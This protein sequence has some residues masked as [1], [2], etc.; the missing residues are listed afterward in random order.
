MFWVRY[1]RCIQ[2]QHDRCNDGQSVLRLTHVATGQSMS[3]CLLVVRSIHCEAN[4]PFSAN[5]SYDSNLRSPPGLPHDFLINAQTQAHNNQVFKRPP[6]SGAFVGE[7]HV[8]GEDSLRPFPRLL[9]F[10]ACQRY[11]VPS[12]LEK[13]DYNFQL[14]QLAC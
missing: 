6:G 13:Q 2:Q 11:S 3:T 7:L 12:R 14:N 9:H 8:V 1:Q 4:V 10:H 5:A